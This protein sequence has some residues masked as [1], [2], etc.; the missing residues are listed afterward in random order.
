M[1]KNE[2][3]NMIL[4]TPLYA[5]VHRVRALLLH[6]GVRTNLVASE[7]KEEKLHKSESFVSFLIAERH[8]WEVSMG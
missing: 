2:R 4:G 5:I 6:L 1:N 3:E 7:S 8:R